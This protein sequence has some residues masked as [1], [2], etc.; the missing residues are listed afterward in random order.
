LPFHK[1]RYQIPNCLRPAQQAAKQL[2]LVPANI[3]RKA[4]DREPWSESDA[5][6]K[7]TVCRVNQ[8]LKE[9]AILVN[10]CG[11]WIFVQLSLSTFQKP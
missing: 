3:I 10:L 5:S 9:S 2:A 4:L 1:T 7:K 11:S 6:L 8:I